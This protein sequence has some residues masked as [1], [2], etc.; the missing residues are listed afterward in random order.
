[1]TSDA[2]AK[3][4]RSAG[5][6]LDTAGTSAASYDIEEEMPEKTPPKPAELIEKLEPVKPD[7]IS[8]QDIASADTLRQRYSVGYRIQ[9]FASS[10]RS[11]AER[12]K[13]RL[14]AETKLA[15]YVEYEEGLYK[16]RAGDFAERKDAAQ[17]RLK[18]AG[19]YPGSWIV[20]TT[21]RK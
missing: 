9:V 12:V 11:A 13:E 5:A 17:T 19:A 14:A 15:T 8:V 20:R 4:Q 1:V 6:A 10:D 7:T 18:L 3:A 16:V 21:I 2:H